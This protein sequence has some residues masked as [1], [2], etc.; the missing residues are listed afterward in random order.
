MA[1]V[2]KPPRGICIGEYAAAPAH[3][4]RVQD[5]KPL[6]GREKHIQRRRGV[7]ILKIDIAR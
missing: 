1:R 7:K 2:S 5:W 3:G 4:I 6:R